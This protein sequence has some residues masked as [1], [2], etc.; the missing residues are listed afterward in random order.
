M[1]KPTHFSTLNSMLVIVPADTEENLQQL[2]DFIEQ[3]FCVAL[4]TRTADGGL[5][6][7]THLTK[8]RTH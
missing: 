7:S 2:F 4:V 8:Y 6:G 3:R 1:S 5:I